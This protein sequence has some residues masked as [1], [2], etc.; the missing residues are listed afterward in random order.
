MN[1]W[2][3]N[4]NQVMD[5]KD[6]TKEN[7]NSVVYVA[8]IDLLNNTGCVLGQ[9][10]DCIFKGYNLGGSWKQLLNDN[11]LAEPKS[12]NWLQPNA[13]ADN[14]YTTQG[15]YDEEGRI[16]ITD[17]GPSNFKDILDK[18]YKST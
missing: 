18:L 14:N 9:E 12:I 3:K 15:N 1:A 11:L 7:A 10:S 13:M 8:F 2:D 17:N 16:R 6:I 4:I 5:S